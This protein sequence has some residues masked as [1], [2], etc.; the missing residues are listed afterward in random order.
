MSEFTAGEWSYEEYLYKE[1][2]ND[3]DMVIRTGYEVRVPDTGQ[4]IALVINEVDAR[5]MA[6]AKEMYERLQDVMNTIN[7]VLPY[8]PDG[9]DDLHLQY[10]KNSLQVEADLIDDLLTLID[11]EE[12][13]S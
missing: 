12:A 4:A 3:G 5:L 9:I 13:Q 10:D 6:H 2:D 11:C 7:G 8:V 1:A